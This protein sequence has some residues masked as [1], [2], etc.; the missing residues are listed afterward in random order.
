MIYLKNGLLL[1]GKRL[2]FTLLGLL[3]KLAQ[4][5]LNNIV[6]VLYIYIYR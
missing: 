6:S 2:F 1:I 4:K 3:N 5:L